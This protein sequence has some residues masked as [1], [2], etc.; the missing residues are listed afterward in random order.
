MH[1]LLTCSPLGSTLSVCPTCAIL[2]APAAA[3]VPSCLD[4]CFPWAPTHCLILQ[5]GHSVFLVLG[6]HHHPLLAWADPPFMKPAG[7]SWCP[8]LNLLPHGIHRNI[9]WDL[10]ADDP[11]SCFSGFHFTLRQQL[12]G[13]LA[14]STG[15]SCHSLRP[16]C[17]RITSTF[18]H[19]LESLSSQSVTP[20]F[21]PVFQV[22]LWFWFSISPLIPPA[23]SISA[24]SIW[25]Y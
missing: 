11:Q 3:L 13:F 14:I 22:F 25:L 6:I 15:S 10:C 9:L 4:T 8:F 2:W 12:C 23:T 24:H 21:A 20:P 18:S 7:G 17:T 1:S 16:N 19:N 5:W